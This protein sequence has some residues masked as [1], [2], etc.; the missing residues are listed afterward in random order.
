MDWYCS[1]VRFIGLKDLG[2]YL[3]NSFSVS[4]KTDS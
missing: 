2:L 3:C 4:E 1:L